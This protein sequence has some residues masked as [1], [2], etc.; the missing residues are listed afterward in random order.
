MGR[1]LDFA[2]ADKSHLI[3]I[4]IA[5]F[6]DQRRLAMNVKTGA[7]ANFV[8]P[9]SNRGSAFALFREVGGRAPFQGFGQRADARPFC[10]GFENQVAYGRQRARSL[11]WTRGERFGH[12]WW[13]CGFGG[14]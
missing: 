14:F 2:I 3:R 11:R 5:P 12:I 13:R 8:P 10:G 1:N 9:E 7:R 4:T 6:A